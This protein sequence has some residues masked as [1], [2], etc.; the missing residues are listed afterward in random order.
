MTKKKNLAC[1]EVG[2]TT[3]ILTRSKKKVLRATIV[4]KINS[5]FLTL[6]SIKHRCAYILEDVLLFVVSF[7]KLSPYQKLGTVKDENQEIVR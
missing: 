5:F 4:A 3:Q 2:Q 7:I 6:A 1:E